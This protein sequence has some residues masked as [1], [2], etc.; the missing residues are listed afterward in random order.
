MKR[1]SLMMSLR[2]AGST[3]PGRRV[4]PVLCLALGVVVPARAADA[5]PPPGWYSKDGLS[6]VMTS[7]NSS[8]ST[9]G[10]KVELK[11]LWT[12]S[13]FAFFGSAIRSQSAD[14]PRRA[15]GTPTD[16]QV[17]NGETVLK[18]AKYNANTTFDRRVGERLAWQVGGAFERDTFSGISG[19]TLGLAGL[20][21]LWANRKEFTFKT[22]ADVTVTHQTEVV[23]DP[24]TKDTFAGLRL[25]AEAERKFGANSSYVGGLFYDQN[26]QDG[27]DSRLRFPSALSVAMNQRLAL[28]VGLLLVYDHQP[29]LTE[30]PLFDPAGLATGLTVA[31]RAVKLDTTV[32]VSIVVSF[33][34]PAAAP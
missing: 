13:T 4:L 6:F 17:E 29:S 31:A 23:D 14:P 34:P 5:P 30:V 16:F 22:A 10:A 26:L 19:R 32:T 33:A 7:G 20:S 11:R 24:A 8:A 9:F 18:A 15:I 21:Y 12:K 28:Q 2:M 25:S 1:G 3:T 27:A